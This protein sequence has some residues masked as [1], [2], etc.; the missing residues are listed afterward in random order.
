MSEQKHAMRE[1]ERVK[2]EQ[3]HENVSLMNYNYCMIYVSRI[4][5]NDEKKMENVKTKERMT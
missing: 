2:R 3:K 5:Q 1:I 4:R